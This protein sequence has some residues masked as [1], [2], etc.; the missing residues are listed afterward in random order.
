M[1]HARN[2]GAVAASLWHSDGD[3]AIWM[4]MA[5]VFQPL[6]CRAARFAFAG[7]SPP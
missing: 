4:V 5:H 7:A 6:R 1:C 3:V 2:G